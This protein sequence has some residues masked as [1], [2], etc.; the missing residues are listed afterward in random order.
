VRQTAR[1]ITLPFFDCFIYRRSELNHGKKEETEDSGTG[2]SDHEEGK[3]SRE[4]G[5]AGVQPESD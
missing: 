4:R 2:G 3:G 5:S 1:K